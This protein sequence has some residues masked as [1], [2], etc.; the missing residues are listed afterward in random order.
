VEDVDC[1]DGGHCGDDRVCYRC[2][3]GAQNGFEKGVDCGGPC[4]RCLG[5]FCASPDEC[6]G[7]SCVD[8][9]YCNGPCDQ[10]CASC[11]N[12]E[13]SCTALPKYASDSDPACDGNN[14]CDGSGTCLAAPGAFCVSDVDCASYRCNNK[15]CAKLAGETCASPD[16]CVDDACVSG[17]CGM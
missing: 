1:L 5:E 8:G 14:A 16:E 13:G 6:K 4:K 17:V 11:N 9:H 3:D 12:A 7:G 10:A 15:R 2:D